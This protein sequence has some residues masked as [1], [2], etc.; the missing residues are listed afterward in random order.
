MSRAPLTPSEVASVIHSN[1]NPRM[2]FAYVDESGDSGMT[3][4]GTST[5]SLGCALVPVDYWDLR[6]RL[7][8]EMRTSIRDTYGVR[9]RDEIKAN[10]LVGVGKRFAELKLGDGQV[11]DIYQRHIGIASTVCSGTFGVV[12][13]KDKLRDKS[14][15]VF[16]RSWLYLL[17]RLRKRSETTGVPILIVHDNGEN[18][19]LKKLYRKF[20]RVNWDFKGQLVE[21]PLLVEDPV[22]RDSRQSFFIQLADLIAYAASRKVVPPSA[23]RGRICSAEMWD[24]LGNVRVTE[25]SI[26]RRDGL[27][28]WPT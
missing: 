18:D 28:V 10:W 3:G 26:Q 21:A 27:V 7:L 9:L 1:A 17:E 6:L 11:R 2:E 22:S 8:I 25:V 5:Y 16:E 23:R 4:G 15:D 12:V 24:S 13:Q 20:R 19:R 14:I